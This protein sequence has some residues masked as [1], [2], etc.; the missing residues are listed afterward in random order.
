MEQAEPIHRAIGQRVWR[1]PQGHTAILS[2]MFRG[3]QQESKNLFQ[4]QV[5]E[6]RV[7][8]KAGDSGVRPDKES[9]TGNFDWAGQDIPCASLWGDVSP[10][11]GN[12][13]SEQ[14]GSRDHRRRGSIRRGMS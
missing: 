8:R 6:D 7:Q 4:R 2:I 10:R 5:P 12:Q 13:E 14:H 9:K 3:L 11:E 1:G